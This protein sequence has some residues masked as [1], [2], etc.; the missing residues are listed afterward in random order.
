[1]KDLPRFLE[2]IPSV[3]IVYDRNVGQYLR[4]IAPDRPAFP[5]D[6]SEQNKNLLTVERICRFLLENGAG[7]DSLVLGVGGGITTDIAGF[8]ASVYKRG[9][10]YAVVPTSLLAMVDAG[11]GGKTG[12]NLDGYKNILG[13]FKQ[14]LYTFI[15]PEF[16]QTLPE[17]EFRAGSAELLK[18]FII[19]D[20]NDYEK[21]VAVLRKQAPTVGE[22]APLIKSA[23][24][25]KE[26]IVSRDPYEQGRRRV[27]N[28]GHTIAHAIEWR[29]NSDPDGRQETL[30]SHGEAVAIGIIW[31]AR[32]SE[33]L[34]SAH[35]GVA[36]ELESD[37][38]SCCLPTAL[39]YPVPELKEA[40][41]RD[42]KVEQGM[43]YEP[44]IRKI[45]RVDIVRTNI[46]DLF[47]QE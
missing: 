17:R 42:K 2:N 15:Y 37:F 19:D 4:D 1:M 41:C 36:A 34:H 21:A 46:E 32:R 11:T 7:R 44:L 13:A 29:Q 6:A 8:A 9:V 26:R 38:R 10:R 27:L 18:T 12:V 16:L 43:I 28:L 25:I 31:T 45:G 14:P 30:Y 23:A 20:R 24:D 22:I 5:I 33:A 39:P 35:P 47:S 40:A 3:Y